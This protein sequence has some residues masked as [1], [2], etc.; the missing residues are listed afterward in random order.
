MA[1]SADTSGKAP[2]EFLF[3]SDG[4]DELAA[5]TEAALRTTSV[6]EHRISVLVGP[7]TR[8]LCES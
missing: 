1:H 8:P 6:P 2:S 4:S 7:G 5:A 3:V